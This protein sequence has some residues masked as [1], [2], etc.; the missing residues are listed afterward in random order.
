MAK[1][2]ALIV[3]LCA[4]APAVDAGD[5]VVDTIR[6]KK[7]NEATVLATALQ[8][9]GKEYKYDNEIMAKAYERCEMK[10]NADLVPCLIHA[11]HVEK[12]LSDHRLHICF[13]TYVYGTALQCA[14]ICFSRYNVNC[15]E[16]VGDAVPNLMDC[17]KNGPY[18]YRLVK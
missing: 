13:F 14:M 11:L 10:G 15:L 17:L 18:K 8:A 6:A 12:L 16:C 9:L 7:T 1:L 2:W 4:L 5:T 3:A